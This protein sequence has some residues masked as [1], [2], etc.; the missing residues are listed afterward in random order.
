M[1]NFPKILFLVL[2]L[3]PASAHAGSMESSD[4][5]SALNNPEA[6]S[7]ENRSIPYIRYKSEN[8]SRVRPEGATLWRD[9]SKYQMTKNKK[10]LSSQGWLP[11]GRHNPGT[12][13]NFRTRLR[14]HKL[15]RKSR[16]IF[17]D[18]CFRREDKICWFFY[19]FKNLS[20]RST[21]FLLPRQTTVRWS[22]DSTFFSRID[23]SRSELAPPADSMTRANGA[24]S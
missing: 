13:Q 2:A 16:Q 24:H 20:K 15:Q 10:T 14:G 12:R 3:L 4:L 6:V 18:P 11:A 8:P 19:A 21:S 22:R 9:K 23:F 1:K 7:R 5:A 17:L